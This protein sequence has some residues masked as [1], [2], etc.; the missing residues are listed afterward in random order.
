MVSNSCGHRDRPH[1]ARGR[2]KQCHAEYRAANPLRSREVLTAM[3]AAEFAEYDTLEPTT[4]ALE[5]RT[6]VVET[7][8]LRALLA[9]Y[10]TNGRF[11]DE[12]PDGTYIKY[13]PA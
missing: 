2:C 5:E 7:A 8:E 9:K 4:Q 10:A 1:H 6:R 3:L 11:D 13:R 12:R